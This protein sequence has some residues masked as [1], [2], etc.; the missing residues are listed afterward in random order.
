[1]Q[2]AHALF[3]LGG[4]EVTSVM[5]STVI[6]TIILCGFAIYVSAH[7]N[8]V[9]SGL[10]NVVEYILESVESFFTGII[11]PSL[12][13]QYMPFL[14]SLFLFILISN[15]WGLLP[16]AGHLPGISAPTSSISVTAALAIIV[17]LVTHY[18]GIRKNGLL[19]YAKH[20]TKPIAIIMPLL[21]IEEIVRPLSL[22][23]RLYGNIFGEETVA[24]ILFEMVPLVA[25]VP[26]YI[27]SL[28]MGFMQALL[29][30]ILASVY[31]SGAA[32]EG[33]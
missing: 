1:M 12:I 2:E 27:L 29:F 25:P 24:R 11:G 28:L 7:L 14:C 5:V 20:F 22:T 17:F 26:I 9:P 33:H 15:Y 13:R 32:G 30:V 3:Q 8:T 16:L 23:L 18:T 10:Q 19:G 21:L 31:I 6:I 4:I